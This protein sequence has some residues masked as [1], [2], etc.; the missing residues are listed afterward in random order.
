M[1]FLDNIIYANLYISNR[2][3]CDGCSRIW[4][5]LLFERCSVKLKIKYQAILKT[6]LFG[7]LYENF[8][9]VASGNEKI[10][11]NRILKVVFTDILNSYKISYFNFC[12]PIIRTF[13]NFGLLKQPHYTQ[14]WQAKM[15]LVNVINL[16][17][18]LSCY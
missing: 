9:D 11:A 7:N 17:F 10:K 1:T 18:Y 5:L 13:E 14:F 15:L 4:S 12:S 2:F 6:L 16:S 3:R 8:T